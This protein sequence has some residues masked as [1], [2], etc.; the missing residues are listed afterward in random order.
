MGKYIRAFLVLAMLIGFVVLVNSRGASAANSVDITYQASPKQIDLSMSSNKDDPCKDQKDNNK[1]K[2]KCKVRSV[3]PPDDDIEVCKRGE[4]SVGG[5]A[6]LDVKNLRGEDCLSAYTRDADPALDQLPQGSGAILSDVI[7]MTL[8]PRGGVLKVCF[9][10]PPGEKAQIYSTKGG[11]W[12]AVKTHVKNGV[13][14]AEV[15]DT[16]GYALV[17]R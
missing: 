17:G 2:D 7:V 4:Y 13:A 3:I 9:A 11:T 8:P 14:C 1:D 5:V 10:V 12:T 16:G 15:K 6:I